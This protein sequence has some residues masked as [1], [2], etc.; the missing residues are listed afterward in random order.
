MHAR[1][2]LAEQNRDRVLEMYAS[3]AQKTFAASPNRPVAWL[4]EGD[5]IQ[6]TYDDQSSPLSMAELGA[7][8]GDIVCAIKSNQPNALVAIDHSAWLADELTERFWAAMPLAALDFIWTTGVGNNGGFLNA[9]A[10]ASSY[11]AKTARYVHLSNI[12]GLGILVDT[13]FGASQTADSWTG[14]STGDLSACWP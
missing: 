13:S 5:F 4:L 14:T 12:T 11:N 9:D 1:R 3:Y 10:S 2:S 8:A 7:L 6:Y